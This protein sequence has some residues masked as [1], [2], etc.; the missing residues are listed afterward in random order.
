MRVKNKK[1]APPD[2]RD[3]VP[4]YKMYEEPEISEQQKEVL[5]NMIQRRTRNI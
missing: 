5:N 1:Q 3:M 2:P 4:D